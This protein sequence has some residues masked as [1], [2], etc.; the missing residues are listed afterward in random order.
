MGGRGRARHEANAVDPWPCGHQVHGLRCGI[1]GDSTKASLS[2]RERE[3]ELKGKT[4]EFER[5]KL[6]KLIEKEGKLIENERELKGYVGANFVCVTVWCWVGGKGGGEEMLANIYFPYPVF[7]FFWL[8]P[9][10]SDTLFFAETV[11][12]WRLVIFVVAKDHFFLKGSL[13]NA[14]RRFYA[15]P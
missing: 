9:I 2:V 12:G 15:R 8:R 5:K 10:H 14:S 6:R 3:M 4:V 11:K 1:L 13:Q 7:F